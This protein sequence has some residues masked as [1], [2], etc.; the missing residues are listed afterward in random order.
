LTT[1]GTTSAVMG[2]HGQVVPADDTD[3]DAI[4]KKIGVGGTAR[5][6]QPGSPPP[7][8][9]HEPHWPH[10]AI[11]FL[12]NRDTSH[13]R[14]V[15]VAARALCI[16]HATRKR[17]QNSHGQSVYTS[18]PESVPPR[19]WESASLVAML[20]CAISLLLTIVSLTFSSRTAA[21]HKAHTQETH[22]S[23]S[24]LFVE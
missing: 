15:Y 16:W 20:S 19:V 10:S 11:L 21:V 17:L 9:P 12:L 7:E 3:D 5:K 1:G 14:D 13:R 6:P 23:H 2:W 24:L 18:R 8:P 22:P 4:K